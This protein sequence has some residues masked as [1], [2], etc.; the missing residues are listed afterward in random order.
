MKKWVLFLGLYFCLCL[1]AGCASNGTSSDESQETNETAQMI[2]M[3]CRII[4]TENHQF[5][6]AK[7]DGGY[8]DLYTIPLEKTHFTINGESIDLQAPGAYMDLPNQK[9]VGALAVVSYDGSIMESFPAQFSQVTSVDIL[10]SGFDDRC[11]M[12]LDVLESLWEKDSGLNDGLSYIGMDLSQTSLPPAEQSAVG[13]VFAGRHDAELVQGTWDELVEQGYISEGYIDSEPPADN[14]A[15]YQWE[16][17][18]FFSIT[19]QPMEGVYSLVPVTFDAY[20]WRSSLGA[21]FLSDCTA[22]QSAVGEW[23]EYHIGSE[24]IS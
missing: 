23:S 14:P 7:Q 11:A 13:R 12:Y 21:Y 5:L 2:T 10:T 4:N 8:G 19:E 1:M 17:G 18:C 15:F 9:L 20:K 16:D 3:T 6:L 22:L 24:V